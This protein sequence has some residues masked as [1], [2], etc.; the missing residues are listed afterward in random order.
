MAFRVTDAPVGLAEIAA[1]V[2]L[3]WERREKGRSTLRAL[4]VLYLG[5][6]P[7]TSSWCFFIP[8]RQT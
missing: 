7:N 2:H 1:W 8:E 5:F 3:N 6:E 4:E